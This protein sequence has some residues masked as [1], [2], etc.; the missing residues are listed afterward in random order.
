MEK[1]LPIR[2]ER[3]SEIP[4]V[5]HEDGTGRV[6]SVSKETNPQFYQLIEAFDKITGT[7]VLLNTSFNVNGEPIV[8]SPGDALKTFFSCGLTV[9]VI[10]DYLLTK[11]DEVA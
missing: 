3:Q 2:P 7:P 10:G 4:A 6:Q 11:S 1:V 9:L 8:C 5:T